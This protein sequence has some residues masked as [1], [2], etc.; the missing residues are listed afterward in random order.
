MATMTWPKL[1]TTFKF[2]VTTSF[3]MTAQPL[4]I[5]IFW[6]SLEFRQ[7]LSIAPQ[8]RITRSITL[9]GTAGLNYENEI[10]K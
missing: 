6:W 10:H 3:V 8:G 9:I 1:V 5:V 2:D 7:F 4:A